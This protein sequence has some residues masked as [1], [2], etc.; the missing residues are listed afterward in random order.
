MYRIYIKGMRLPVPPSSIEI[1]SDGNGKTI[2]LVN[3][4]KGNETNQAN[5]PK[6]RGL[7]EISFDF[8]LPAS[9]RPYAVYPTGFHMPNYYIDALE[10]IRRRKK[11]VEFVINRIFPDGKVIYDT[12]FD[13]TVEDLVTKDDKEEGFDTIVSIKL[14]EYPP[15]GTQIADIVEDKTTGKKNIKKGNKRPSKKTT[16]KTTYIVKK[17]D[18]LWKIAKK[19]Y[20]DGSSYKAIQSANKIPS[21]GLIHPGDKLVIPAKE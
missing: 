7:K 20:G 10:K 15:E 16:A 11:P 6:L 14:K 12:C 5:I 21:S 9:E 18:C 4:W 17:G 1:S 2:D 3:P 13:V 8:E 19:F